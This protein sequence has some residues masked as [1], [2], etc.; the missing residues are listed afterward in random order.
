MDTAIPRDLAGRIAAA[1]AGIEGVRSALVCSADGAVLG[2]TGVSEP[3]IEAALVSFVS[4][5]AE[6]LPVDGDLRGMGRQL[7]GSHFSHLSMSGAGT[8]AMLFKLSPGSYLSVRIA[9]GRSSA[10]AGPLAALAARAAALSESS[11]RSPRP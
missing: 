2:S 9:P 8:E 11:S 7:A 1:A 5:R 4:A 3:A 6:A 10:A